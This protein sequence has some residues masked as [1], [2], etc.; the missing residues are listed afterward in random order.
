MNQLKQDLPIFKH[1]QEVNTENPLAIFR[2]GEKGLYTTGKLAAVGGVVVGGVVVV[3]G[4]A[5]AGRP[6][7]GPAGCW[8]WLVGRRCCASCWLAGCCLCGRRAGLWSLAGLLVRCCRC[9]FGRGLCWSCFLG[10]VVVG[11]H[12]LAAGRVMATVEPDFARAGERAGGKAL[13]PCR[14]AGGQRSLFE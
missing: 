2:P 13:H 5:G 7:W 9:W 11:S 12:S 4:S 8:F 3:G 14:P 1:I 6:G 10:S